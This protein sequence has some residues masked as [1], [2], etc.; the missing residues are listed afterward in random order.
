[1]SREVTLEEW[2]VDRDVLDAAHLLAGHDLEDT[3]DE[4][5]PPEAQTDVKGQSRDYREAGGATVF[6]LVLGALVMFLVLAAQFE[7]LVHPFVIMLTVPLAILGALLGLHLTGLSLN[8]YS[9]VGLVMLVGLAAKNGILIVEFAN[10][11]RDGG[12]AFAE[13]LEEAAVTRLRPI[14]MTAVT[15]MAGAIPLLVSSGA[16]AE[17]RLVIGTVIFAGVALATVLTLFVVPVAY[18]LLARRTGS[19]GDVSRR[20]ER[21]MVD[22]SVV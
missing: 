16:G 12:R 21:E 3:V 22:D 2:L 5:L 10:Q 20:L 13:A 8:I 7:S 1:M 9:Q 19:V 15:T 17:T 14:L 6:M 11:L 18:D 4:I